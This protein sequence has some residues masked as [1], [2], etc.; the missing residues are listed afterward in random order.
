MKSSEDFSV[1][2]QKKSIWELLGEDLQAK[3]MIK[4]FHHATAFT[5][6]CS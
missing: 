6:K 2:C 4:F 1:I 3:K 5:R